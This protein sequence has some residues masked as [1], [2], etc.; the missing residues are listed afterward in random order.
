MVQSWT[1]S[2]DGKRWTFTLRPGLKFNDG[3]PVTAE[4]CVASLQRWAKKD[5][6]GQ[7]MMAA[8]AELAATSTDT[9]TLTLKQPFG[10]VLD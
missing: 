5:T 10:L 6:L 3:T 2:P 4:D 7:A 9:F 8:G 1:T